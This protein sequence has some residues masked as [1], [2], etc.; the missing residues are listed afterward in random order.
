MVSVSHWLHRQVCQS[1]VTPYHKLS[2]YPLVFRFT[3][4]SSPDRH[5][6]A[7][8]IF[9][10]TSASDSSIARIPSSDVGSYLFEA[11][12]TFLNSLGAPRGLR[13]I[14]YASSDIPKLVA[15][16][17]PQR[18]VLNMAPGVRFGEMGDEVSEEGK[19]CLN[20]ILE[21]S[22]EYWF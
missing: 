11:I 8:A 10:G 15:G 7:L 5:R 19:E 1:T 13:A 6:E 21:N 18:R 12:A 2:T 4:P 20:I 17:L 3:A 22:L 16:T 9:R 14:G